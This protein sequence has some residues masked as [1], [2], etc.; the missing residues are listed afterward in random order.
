[1]ICVA[2]PSHSAPRDSEPDADQSHSDSPSSPDATHPTQ[3]R[4]H[5]S[6]LCNAAVSPGRQS[7]YKHRNVCSHQ[8]MCH[9]DQIP[10]KFHIIFHFSQFDFV[11]DQ[12]FR[13]GSASPSSPIGT[14]SSNTTSPRDTESAML[15]DRRRHRAQRPRQRRNRLAG[16]GQARFAATLRA[17]IWPLRGCQI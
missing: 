11:T 15:R 9:F 14:A 12:S 6:C 7:L 17:V 8:C 3:P 10:R 5:V 16:K 2:W 13:V 1:M 4:H